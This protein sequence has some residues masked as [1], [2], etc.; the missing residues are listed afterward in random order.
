M[1]TTIDKTKLE[2]LNKIID[3]INIV[4]ENIIPNLNIKLKNYGIETLKDG[5]EGYRVQLLSNREGIEIPLKYESDGIKKIISILSA[6]IAMYNNEKILLAVDELDA[7]V[8][9]YL[10]GEILDVIKDNCKGQF[11]FTSHNLRALEKLDKDSIVFTTTNPENR[12]IKFTSVK[13]TNN[14]RDFYLR[15]ILLGGQKEE[16]YNGTNKAYISRAFRKAWRR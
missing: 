16:I 13:S 14:L 8:F 3:Q 7:G 1:I 2:T 9:E 4:V 12:Y 6:L 15:G 11:I 5:R 10:L